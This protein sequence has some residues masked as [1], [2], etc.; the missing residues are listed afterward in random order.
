MTANHLFI[1]L[2]GTG[3]SILRYL[4]RPHRNGRLGIAGSILSQ[5]LPDGG[6]GQANPVS[7]CC[8]IDANLLGL[9]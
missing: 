3:E 6:S 4:T 8:E 1:G 5:I 9:V 7:L 2:G